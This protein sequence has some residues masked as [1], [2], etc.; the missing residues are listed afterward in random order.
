[1]TQSKQVN[2]SAQEVGKLELLEERARVIKDVITAGKVTIQKHVR[3]KVINVPVHLDETYLSIQVDYGDEPTQD[4]LSGDY[5]D[6]EVIARFT[7][8]IAS[9]VSLNGKP[10]AFDEPVE[11][12]LSRETAVVT[13]KTYAVQEVALTTYTDTQTHT[14]AT[15]LQKEVLQVDGEQYLDEQSSKH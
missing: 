9:L 10:L 14:L 4:M 3:T 11:L 12:V 2:E 15:Q 8:S 6:K 1:M 7:D 13:K 5:D